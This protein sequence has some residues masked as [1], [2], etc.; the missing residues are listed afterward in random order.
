MAAITDHDVFSYD[1]YTK[2]KKEAKNLKLVL[3][4][5]EFTVAMKCTNGVFKQ[6]HVITLF[7]DSDEEKIKNIEKVLGNGKTVDKNGKLIT[8]S[9]DYDALNNSAYSQDKLIKLLDE[10]GLDVVMIAHQK[11]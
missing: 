3:P 10:I 8:K 4:G 6:I 11:K 2:F 9:P 7:N 1:L 5:V